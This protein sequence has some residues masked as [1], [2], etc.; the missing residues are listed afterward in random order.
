MGENYIL[1]PAG[2]LTSSYRAEQIA[3]KTGLEWM[4]L[5]TEF[6]EGKRIHMFSDSKSL[7]N[8]LQKGPQVARSENEIEIWKLIASNSEITTTIHIQWI[9]GHAN[10][11][12]NETADKTAKLATKLEQK[13]QPIDISTAKSTIKAHFV[14]EWKRSIKRDKMPQ[15]AKAPPNQKE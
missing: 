13:D 3:F 4:Q 15:A 10:L 12:A 6:V 8:K 5:N 14:N 7:I 1:A 2:N 9:P 11:Y